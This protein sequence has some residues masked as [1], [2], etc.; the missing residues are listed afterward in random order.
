MDR[1]A[2]GITTQVENVA[3]IRPFP[4]A[5]PC[6]MFEKAVVHV[7]N[8]RAHADPYQRQILAGTVFEEG[9]RP[10]QFD[11]TNLPPMPRCIRWGANRSINRNL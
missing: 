2:F 9:V 8:A 5:V 11:M 4:V 7:H 10:V 3:T 6:T 1:I